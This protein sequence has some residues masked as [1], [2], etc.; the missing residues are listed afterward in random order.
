MTSQFAKIGNLIAVNSD[1]D[2]VIALV[3]QVTEQQNN[4][5]EQILKTYR[6]NEIIEQ[7]EKQRNQATK[8]VVYAASSDDRIEQELKE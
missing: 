8:L 6:G 1:T 5:Q 3:E 4:L 7:A 2:P